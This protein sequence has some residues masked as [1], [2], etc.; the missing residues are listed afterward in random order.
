[1]SCTSIVSVLPVR[2]GVEPAVFPSATREAAVQGS[3][4]CM[5]YVA[6]ADLLQDIHHARLENPSRDAMP[7]EDMPMMS[8]LMPTTGV[9]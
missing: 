5:A 6:Y 9:K 1:M 3:G 7:R 8:P 4:R 2:Y